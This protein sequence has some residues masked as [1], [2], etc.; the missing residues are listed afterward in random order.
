[1]NYWEGQLLKSIALKDSNAAIALLKQGFPINYSIKLR[2]ENGL[3]QPGYS[4]LLLESINN[5]LIDLCEYLLLNGISVNSVDSLSRNPLHLAASIGDLE[6]IQLLIKYNAN[7]SARDG[8]GNTV[9]H[10]AAMNNHLIIVQYIADDLKFPVVVL[11]KLM[12]KPLDLCKSVQENCKSLVEIEELEAIIQYLWRKEEEYKSNSNDKIIRYH[13]SPV[14]QNSQRTSK[15]HKYGI[16][17][18][19]KQISI[20]PYYRQ[21]TSVFPFK[22]RQTIQSYLK[23]KHNAIK[24]NNEEKLVLSNISQYSMRSPSPTIKLPHLKKISS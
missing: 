9:L 12:Q 18:N 10:V 11:N 21:I 7:L 19:I 14:I 8:L 1:M 24:K 20:F 15:I 5:Q 23:D 4:T 22:G 2:D 16:D 17:Y 6:I 13:L 3:V